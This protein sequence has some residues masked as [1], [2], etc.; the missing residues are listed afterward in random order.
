MDKKLLAMF[1]KLLA[2]DEQ[3][4]PDSISPE[5][6]SKL[7]EN[8][9]GKLFIKPEDF[10]NLQKSLS[11]KDVDLKK[12][13]K[14]IEDSKKK[15]EEGKTEAEKALVEM[16][17]KIGELTETIDTLNSTRKSEALLKQY[18]D[19]MP[20]LLVGKSE[21]EV[22]KIVD[23]QRTL[24]KKLYGDS[25]HFAPPDYSTEAEVDEAIED[26]KSD[27]TKNGVN[28]AVSVMQLERQ[29]GDL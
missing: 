3:A 18:P 16:Q 26:V 2:L 19:I 25:Q 13:E 10:K 11:Q 22:E 29:K 24:N 20:E 17:E 28:S 27:K 6:F 1:R 8:S 21:E 9:D 7:I 12:L 4:L 23:K 15:G 5:D 14:L